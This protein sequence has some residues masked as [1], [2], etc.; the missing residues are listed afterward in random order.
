MGKNCERKE[1]LEYIHISCI[2]YSSK[3]PERDFGKI[4]AKKQGLNTDGSV[5]YNG[6]MILLKAIFGENSIPEV[7]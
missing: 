4:L 1:K 5:G 7:C 3:L 2:L 6:M